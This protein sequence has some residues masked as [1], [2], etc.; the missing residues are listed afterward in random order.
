MREQLLEQHQRADRLRPGCS[1]TAAS[2]Q[3]ASTA[4]SSPDELGGQR[5]DGRR[6]G[7]HPLAAHRAGDVDG[8]HHRA[9]GADPLAHDDVARPRAPAA[10]PAPRACGRGRCRRSRR[11]RAGSPA[12][13]APRRSSA[14]RRG[15]GTASRA[16]ICRARAP[17]RRVWRPSLRSP[18]RPG[19]A[20]SS[21]IAAVRCHRRAGGAPVRPCGAG[22]RDAACRR[23]RLRRED[24]RLLGQLLGLAP[25]RLASGRGAVARGCSG[26]SASTALQP[27]CGGRGLQDEPVLPDLREHLLRR[28]CRRP[29]RGG[30]GRTARRSSRPARSRRTARRRADEIAAQR[31]RAA[32]ATST[33]SMAPRTLLPCRTSGCSGSPG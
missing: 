10:R 24:R 4:R 12:S 13:P 9:P 19:S 20:G 32:A 15:R 11:G 31:R 8:Q 25:Q 14:S 7:P 17:H 33:V 30:S 29:R 21:V 18:R 1:S 2:D 27:G 5:P 22:Q 28:S 16:A 6:G 26:E 3:N 23:D